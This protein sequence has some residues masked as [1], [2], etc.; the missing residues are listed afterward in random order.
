MSAILSLSI[1][2]H[3]V[4]TG[5]SI[6]L[7]R[8]M[9]DW[10]MGFLTA[11]L[12]LMALRQTMT[13]LT[14][15]ESRAI[16][17][18]SHTIELAGLV[19]SIMA[20]LAVFCL[21]R[22]ITER[23]RAVEEL[24]ECRDDNTKLAVNA[25]ERSEL[26]EWIDT[27]DTLVGKF[28][29]DGIRIMF[30]E[31]AF[32]AGGVSRDDVV[33]KYFPGTKWWSH[34]EIERARVAECFERAKGGLSSRIDTNFR[35]ADGTSVPTIFNCQPVIDDDGRVKYITAEGK[36][37]LEETRLYAELQEAKEALETRV[38]ERTSELV[39]ANAQLRKEIAE[40]KLVEE[41]LRHSE[42]ILK[43]RNETATIFLTIAGDRKSVV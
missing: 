2:I 6:V 20:L 3:L 21:E 38:R 10:R 12:G 40:R 17:I 37:I 11:M 35:R 29:P 41:A 30:N 4:A 13:L 34:S 16:S 25:Q 1:A 24:Q 31:A 14:E 32:K 18:G 8:R 33:G 9:R 42:G 36:T 5:W 43:I 15:M 7:L 19:V 22:V 26:Q 39:E 23:T 27:F 28:D